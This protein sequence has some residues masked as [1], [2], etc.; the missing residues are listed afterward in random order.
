MVY[1][2]I[3]VVLVLVPIACTQPV[4]QDRS[5]RVSG[6][7]KNAAFQG[8]GNAVFVKD[9]QTGELKKIFDAPKG[10]LATSSPRWDQAGQRL[11]FCTAQPSD[12]KPG[13]STTPTPADGARYAERAVRYTCWLFENAGGKD[14]NPTELFS[15]NCDHVGYIGADLAVRWNRDGT[16]IDYV[17]SASPGRQTLCHFDLQDKTSKRIFWEE[18]EGLVFDRT[19]DGKRLYCLLGT[20]NGTSSTDGLWIEEGNHW[21]HVP[22]TVVRSPHQRPPVLEHLRRAGPIWSTDS[23][24]FA[25]VGFEPGAT[26]EKPGT[27]RLRIGDLTNHQVEVRCTSENRLRDIRWHPDNRRVGVLVGA[28]TANSTSSVL[29]IA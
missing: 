27:Y 16:G 11:I 5:I 22:E 10:T 13:N 6:D 28:K 3:L 9:L 19:P 14:N 1:S 15:A 12:G 17:N 26:E 20:N 29:A 7:G 2:H 4:Q 24:Q 18:A 25:F 23:Q 8:E 21:W